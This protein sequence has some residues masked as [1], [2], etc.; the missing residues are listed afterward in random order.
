M[1]FDNELA[2]EYALKPTEFKYEHVTAPRNSCAEM[3]KIR[4]SLTG[5]MPGDERTINALYVVRTEDYEQYE[6]IIRGN[7]V[8]LGDAIGILEGR[9]PVPKYPERRRKTRK[10]TKPLTDLPLFSLGAA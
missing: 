5:M 8:T 4:R 10:T 2:N 1:I 7:V 6:Y 3:L 9:L